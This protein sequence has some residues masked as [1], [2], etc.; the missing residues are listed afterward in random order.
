[1]S[2][3][4]KLER[5]LSFMHTEH[6]VKVEEWIGRIIVVIIHSGMKNRSSVTCL[7]P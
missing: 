6:L 7:E 2:P 5:P 4:D 1:M 3:F